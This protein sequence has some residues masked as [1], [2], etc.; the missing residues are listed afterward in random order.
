MT[1]RKLGDRR[2]S[3][4]GIGT[5]AIGGPF[6]SNGRP[7]GWG[8]VDDDESIRMIHVAVDAGVRLFD[9]AD[10]YGTGQSERVLGRALAQL[11][12]VLRDEVVVATKFG[13]VFDEATRAAGGQ[14]VSPAAIRRACENS[15]RRLGVDS[16]DLYQLHGGVETAAEASAVVEVLEQLVGQGLIRAFGTSVDAPEVI[17]TFGA[18]QYGQTVQTQANVFGHNDAVLEV[19]RQHDLAVLARTPL[20]MGLLTGKYTVGNRPPA[21]DVRRDTP[22][23]TYFDDDAMAD[24]LQRLDS[25]RELL[26]TDGRTLAQG[27]LGYLWA[28]DPAIIPLPGARTV[29]QAQENAAALTFGPLPEP[30]LKEISTLLADSPE[31]HPA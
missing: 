29:A 1:T 4:L 15:L 23:W 28:L 3:A 30:T 9:T 24:W 19:A 17:A 27:C 26:T 14:D 20:A 13:N 2:T 7:A 18:S 22:W 31:R 12:A 11:P 21:D 5:W 8:P 25:V 6:T 10:I 16:I